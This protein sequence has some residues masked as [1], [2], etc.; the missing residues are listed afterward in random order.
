MTNIVPIS[1]LKNY[2]EVLSSCDDGS[3]VYLT[4]NGRGKYVVQTMLDYEKMKA[5]VQLLA[6]LSKGIDSLRKE[7]GLTVEAAFEG[8]EDQ[9]WPE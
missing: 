4:R 2:T 1:D 8:L 6:D 7:G 5:T 9:R 3:V